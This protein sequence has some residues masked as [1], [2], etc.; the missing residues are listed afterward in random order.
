MKALAE[1]GRVVAAALIAFVVWLV[2]YFPAALLCR[3]FLSWDRDIGGS[4]WTMNRS[5]FGSVLDS[6]TI[7]VIVAIISL[8]AFAKIYKGHN[9]I[10]LLFGGLALSAFVIIFSLLGQSQLGGGFIYVGAG[11][12]FVSVIFAAISFRFLLEDRRLGQNRGAESDQADS[13]QLRANTA[14]LI[15]TVCENAMRKPH[16]RSAV[17]GTLL[18]MHGGLADEDEYQEI[19]SEAI[20]MAQGGVPIEELANRV[21]RG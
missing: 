6:L 21:R 3:T 17:I 19:I 10:G 11:S 16:P 1:L 18:G 14:D 15:E 12:T 20:H 5:S 8:I 9:S 4:P 2:A 7:G 13:D